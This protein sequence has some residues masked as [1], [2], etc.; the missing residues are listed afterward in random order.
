MNKERKDF[1]TT[2]EYCGYLNAGKTF[3]NRQMYAEG[4]NNQTQWAKGW[5]IGKA[6]IEEEGEEKC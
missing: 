4:T 5:D 6:E 2:M 1:D 3:S